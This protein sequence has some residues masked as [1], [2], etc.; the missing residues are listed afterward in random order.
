VFG[1]AVS[2]FLKSDERPRCRPA[3]SSPLLARIDRCG[4]QGR[5][6]R[7]YPQRS[8]H[9][10]L[11][12][13][14]CRLRALDFAGSSRQAPVKSCGGPERLGPQNRD[15][16]G[17]CRGQV[18]TPSRLAVTHSRAYARARNRPRSRLL[19]NRPPPRRRARRRRDHRRH[20]RHHTRP[21]RGGCRREQHVR[22]GHHRD[23]CRVATHR[24]IHSLGYR[25]RPSRTTTSSKN[26]SAFPSGTAARRR[27]EPS[28]SRTLLP[29]VPANRS[30]RVSMSIAG[31]PGSTTPGQ[32]SGRERPLVHRRLPV[33]PVHPHRRVRRT[34]QIQRPRIPARS[35]IAS[36]SDR[37]EGSGARSSGRWK[38][39]SR[40][41]WEAAQS[42]RR[43][44]DLLVAAGAR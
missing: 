32:A 15:I 30:A 33:A 4:R 11:S 41:L 7:A 12:R 44:R 29:S 6:A 2:P 34:V 42:P 21:Y 25:S 28:N 36:G 13:N 27:T 31:G 3:I 19:D 1:R 40:W 18:E 20:P 14:L 10:P 8:S 17:L 37:R 5:A 26:S 16:P 35:T 43:L 22:R 24:G 23:G 9:T 38:R 39:N